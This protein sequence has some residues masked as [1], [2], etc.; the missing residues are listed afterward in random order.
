[1]KFII[2]LCGALVLNA[3]ANLS[4]K[5]GTQGG[6]LTNGGPVGAIKTVLGSP[7]LLIGLICFGCNVFL[8][9]YALQS[10]TL[11]ISVAYPIMVGGGYAI[12]SVS[13]FFL[14]S[15]NERL[16]AGQ[17]VGVAL[18]LAGVLTVAFLTPAAPD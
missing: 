13:A 2:A 3:I 11:Q 4:M 7:V 10:K 12:I 14:P 1:M 16:S 5:I 15:L 6:G 8:Y 18:I 17:W 9:M